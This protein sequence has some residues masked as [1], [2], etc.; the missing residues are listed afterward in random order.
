M[1]E[2]TVIKMI[3]SGQ[4]RFLVPFDGKMEEQRLNTDGKEVWMEIEKPIPK[5]NANYTFKVYFKSLEKIR[6]C[7]K[8]GA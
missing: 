1:D 5:F 3:Q 6:P 8:K 2:K 4:D 7:E